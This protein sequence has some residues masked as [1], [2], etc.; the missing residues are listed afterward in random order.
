[1]S[2]NYTLDEDIYPTF[3][4][5]DGTEM[6]LLAFIQVTNPTKVKVGEQ[7]RAEEEARLLDS[8][9]GRVV[10][11][12]PV[13][14]THADSELEASVDRLFDEGGSANQGDFVAGGRQETETKIVM[15]VRFIAD[16]NVVTEKPNHPR[17][18][19]QAVTDASGSSHP[20]KKLRGD[21]KTSSEPATG[22]KSS[23]VLKEL[24]ASSMLNVEVGVATVAT[25]PMITSSVSAT[26]EHESGAPT[27][28][29]T[30]LNIRTIGA[31]KRSVV[32][33]L[34]MTETVITT[35]VASI[36]S[37][38]ASKTSTKVISLV[39]ALMFHDSDSTRTV[40]LNAVEFIDHLASPVLFAQ[41]CEMDYHHLFTEFNVGTARQACLNTEVRM[42]TEYCLSKRRRLESEYE[43][44]ADFLKARDA[45]VESLKA[46]LLLK[47]TEA[48][49]DGDQSSI[50]P[51]L[52]FPVPISPK[53]IELKDLNVV[54]SSLRSQKDNLVDQV[55]ALETTCSGL[56]DQVSRY[57]RLKEQIEEFQDSQMN[58]VN[59][60][61]AKLDA[62]LLEMALHLKENFYHRL[63]TII[64]GRRI[65]SLTI[66]EGDAGW[67]GSRY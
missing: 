67:I 58:I 50:G 65:S 17:K 38:P 2:R 59:D 55:H 27:D 37:A 43:K 44:Q 25:L 42:R 9:V 11:L 33:P 23:S 15:G 36:P 21:H 5:D 34:V 29:I 35:N 28:S 30:G 22:D 32:P 47:E 16:E 14:L 63:L 18:K 12:L 24:L 61:V 54:V 19:R 39:L 31:S 40:R 51:L 8:T 66:E 26:P 64:C 3:L 1:M 41:I 20:P 57:E 10:L 13:A 4:H 45:K 6:D 62:D 60:K 7:E 56:R 48:A 53:D 46:Q 49:A 52:K